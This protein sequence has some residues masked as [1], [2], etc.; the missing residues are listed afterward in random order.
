MR[1]VYEV[2]AERDGDWWRLS[3]PTV[4]GAVSQ[5]RRLSDVDDYIRDAI[6]YVLGV[7]HDSFD[8]SVRQVGTVHTD[9]DSADA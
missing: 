7:Q 6:A 9:R 3:V 1:P 5:V 2:C 8:I 4:R